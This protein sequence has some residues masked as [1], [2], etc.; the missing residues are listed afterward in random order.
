VRKRLGQSFPPEGMIQRRLADVAW[1]S[2]L[3]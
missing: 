1:H 3:D 2:L